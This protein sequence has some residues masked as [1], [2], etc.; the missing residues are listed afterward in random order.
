MNKTIRLLIFD[1]G[2]VLYKTSKKAINRAVKRFLISKGLRNFKEADEI[3][4]KVSKLG[5][6]GKLS[7][8]E[9]QERWLE[10]LGLDKKLVEEWRRIDRNVIWKKHFTRFPKVNETLRE[11]KK[12]GYKLAILSDSVESRE[13]KIES[14]KLLRIDYKLF[15]GIFTSHDIGYEK[16]HKK[17]FEK[18]LRSFRIKTKEAIFIG[19][20]KDEIEGAKKVG[21]K[22]VSF[23]NFRIKADHFFR[24][25]ENLVKVV[26]NIERKDS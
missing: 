9:C 12:R 24:K 8:K 22:T 6:I 1:A 14:L 23:R 18:V 15:D 3:W 13:E 5:R 10:E 11:L 2:D 26:E 16:P 19:H 7:W 25:F 4:D 17:T 21:L 20:A